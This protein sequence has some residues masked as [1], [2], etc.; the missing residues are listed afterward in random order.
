M[1]N[2]MTGFAAAKGEAEGFSWAWD[3]RSVNARGLD[4]RLRVPDWIEGL[5]PAAR[6]A[7]Q[8]AVARG[9]VSLT[10]KVQRDDSTQ[11]LHIDQDALDRVLTAL[12]R[13]EVDASASHDMQLSATSAAEVLAMPGVTGSARPDLDTGPLTKALLGDL[14]ELLKAFN[15]TRGGEGQALSRVIEGQLVQIETLSVDAKAAAAARREATALRL[16]ENLARVLENTVGAEPDR[17]AQE[18]AMIAVKADM[19]EEIDRL[20]A[21]VAA[22]R[23]LLASDGA[24]GRKLD[25]LAQEFNREANTLCSKAQ[26]SDLTRIGLDL[27]A[28]ID[29]MR[30]QVQNVE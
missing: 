17:V 27:K 20:H 29:Q 5:E 16:R 28:V 10:L 24:V 30:E 4:I 12:K 7:I 22:A 3:V 26:S 21:H 15:A 1:T 25:F 19:T 18:L 9:S 6:S 23:Q 14:Q 11:K 13:I 2:S 8:K